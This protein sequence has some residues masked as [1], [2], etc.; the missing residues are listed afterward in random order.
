MVELMCI[1]RSKLIVYA[2]VEVSLKTSFEGSFNAYLNFDV[3]ADV[4]V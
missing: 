4:E 1:V 3:K 2:S